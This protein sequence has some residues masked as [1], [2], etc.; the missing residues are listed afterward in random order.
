M[1]WHR[2]VGSCTSSWAIAAILL[3]PL[4]VFPHAA[5][6]QRAAIDAAHSTVTVR[7][8]K[9]GLLS[10]LAHNHEI[11]APVA[12]GNVDAHEKNVEL[13]FNVA[14]MKVLDPGVSDSEK[15]EI[16]AT[17][18]GQK[19]LDVAQ[20]PSISFASTA[21]AASGQDRYQV[22]GTL[23]LHGAS[24]PVTLGV[25]LRDEKYTGTVTLKQTDFGITP[26]KIAG[27]AVKVKD[28]IDVEFSIAPGTKTSTQPGKP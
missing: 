27:G 9:S 18:K 1:L 7:V 12:S 24:R 19:V 11:H 13:T 20:F 4:G 23:K 16:E 28:E 17:M 10:G 21:V 6:A 2:V 3:M 22:T 8:Y 5:N 26:V 15:Q 14:D 25:V